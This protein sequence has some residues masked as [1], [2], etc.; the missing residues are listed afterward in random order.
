MTDTYT[1]TV[2]EQFHGQPIAPDYWVRKNGTPFVVTK[3][4]ATATYLVAA[5]NQL[6]LEQ[7]RNALRQSN[8]VL[9][10]RESDAA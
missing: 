8:A 4:L 10:E 2:R 6:T 9:N 3:S 7:E 1:Y 5:L